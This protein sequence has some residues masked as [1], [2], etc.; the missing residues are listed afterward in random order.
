MS[1][2]PYNLT[3]SVETIKNTKPVKNTFGAT[4]LRGDV[5]K[6]DEHENSTFTQANEL[7]SAAKNM[8]EVYGVELGT[9]PS[10]N[11]INKLLDKDYRGV[12]E[13]KINI[14]LSSNSNLLK[15][16][17]SIDVTPEKI[18]EVIKLM[19]DTTNEGLNKRQ[20]LQR[21]YETSQPLTSED[22]KKLIEFM[23]FSITQGIN[24]INKTPSKGR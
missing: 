6:F 2:P 19:K 16:N 21:K 24:T 3:L 8:K 13:G 18:S 14:D 9:V 17:S 12:E 10:V 15:G 23:N 7:V 4:D 22:N 5:D 1:S 20:E 11:E